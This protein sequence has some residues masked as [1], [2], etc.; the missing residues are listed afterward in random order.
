MFSYSFLAILKLKKNFLLT[1]KLNYNN[2]TRY[3]SKTK[4]FIAKMMTMILTL[5]LCERFK[6]SEIN[7]FFVVKFPL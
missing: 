6:K 4:D 7:F 3:L 5:L 2:P 1:K